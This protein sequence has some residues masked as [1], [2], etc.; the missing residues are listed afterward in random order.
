MN[1]HYERLLLQ[2]RIW[3]G[4]PGCG[5]LKRAVI[6]ASGAGEPKK[7]PLVLMTTDEIPVNW[8]FFG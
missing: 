1:V 7:S 2:S 8:D 5:V 6:Q 4:D 3:T